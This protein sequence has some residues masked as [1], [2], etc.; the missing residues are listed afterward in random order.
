MKIFIVC[1][2][3]WSFYNQS[4]TQAQEKKY[5]VQLRESNSHF[6]FTVPKRTFFIQNIIDSRADTSN[7]GLVNSNIEAL[8]EGGTV[9]ALNSLISRNT[10]DVNFDEKYEPI[11]MEIKQLK[12]SET[13][14]LSRE[15]GHL[16]MTLVF[17]RKRG[18]EFIPAFT[19]EITEDDAGI[20]VTRGH[21]YR[22]KDGVE[23]A[24]NKLQLFLSTE[25]T[26]PF[27]S[28]TN[29]LLEK[30]V[31]E[32][33]LVVQNF[34]TA[35]SEEDNI[36]KNPKRRY[37]IYLTYEDF[38]TNRPRII[39]NFN[40]EYA[41]DSSILRLFSNG[42]IFQLRGKFFGFCD[43]KNIYISGQNYAGHKRFTKVLEMGTI[44]AWKDDIFDSRDA[45]NSALFGAIGMT[46]ANGGR[47]GDCIALDT[48]TGIIKVMLAKN[49]EALLVNDEALLKEYKSWTYMRKNANV[50][51]NTLKDYNKTYPLK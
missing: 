7:I 25:N 44:I 38:R 40:A 34:D 31:H 30:L 20:D 8:M 29:L 50:I 18:D 26:S 47:E 42:T 3:F 19:T 35:I 51:L 15:I 11:V 45:V 41:K 46:I 12:I 22:I 4:Y 9:P 2:L 13:A 33:G 16:D 23:K 14:K 1:L 28:D 39:G 48:R 49:M 27:Y 32:E 6:L 43:T 21:S 5:Y 36:F 24:L 37:G 10:L 17:K